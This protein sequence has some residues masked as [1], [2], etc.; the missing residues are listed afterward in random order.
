MR[1]G[2]GGVDWVLGARSEERGVG[3]VVRA[4]WR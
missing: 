3:V 4:R 1:V 2:G